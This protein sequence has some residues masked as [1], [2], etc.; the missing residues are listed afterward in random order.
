MTDT[1]T[2]STGYGPTRKTRKSA[3]REANA[4]T[5]TQPY[6]YG[7]RESTTWNGDKRIDPSYTEVITTE[8]QSVEGGF[9]CAYITTRTYHEEN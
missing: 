1:T 8:V 9:A 2:V 6:T 7:P 5:N 4:W 3:E